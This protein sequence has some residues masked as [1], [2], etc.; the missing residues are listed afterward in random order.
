MIDALT[1]VTPQLQRRHNF[2]KRFR[3]AGRLAIVVSLGFLAL[4]ALLIAWQGAGALTQTYIAV[5]V[6]LCRRQ[7]IPKRLRKR[8]SENS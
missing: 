7:L 2:E 8:A 5:E 1:K 6:D 3:W 4:M